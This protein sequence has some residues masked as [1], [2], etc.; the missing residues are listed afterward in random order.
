MNSMMNNNRS[1]SLSSQRAALEA[2]SKED[3]SPPPAPSPQN[4][5][6][7]KLEQLGDDK[8]IKMEIDEDGKQMG[9]K[10]KSEDSED[11]KMGQKWM[12]TEIKSEKRD[13]DGQQLDMN[14][15]IIGRDSWNEHGV[16]TESKLDAMDVK[17]KGEPMSPPSSSDSQALVK[18]EISLEPVPNTTDKKKKCSKLGKLNKFKHSIKTFSLQTAFKPEKLCE[19]LIP[20]LEKL[21]QQEPESVPFRSP[22]D[23]IN[24]GIPDY[25][26]IIKKPMD[27]GT[28]EKKL[29]KGEYSDPWEYV[30][31]V[32]LMFD[33]AWLYNRKTS[34]VYRYCSKVCSAYDKLIQI[35]YNFNR[36]S[37]I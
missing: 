11:H 21:V 28:I 12:D 15:N 31:D 24:L 35:F 25:L 29:R 2:A 37:V 34:R 4:T 9:D 14:T 30:D 13:P 26:D 19:A 6:R 8:K 16:K 32:W 22:V 7:G 27:L 5:N 33:N 36:F 1:S 23:P 18:S 10:I 3:D 20:T 17:I